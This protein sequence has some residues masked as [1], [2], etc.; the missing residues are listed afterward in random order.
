MTETQTDSPKTN[1]NKDGLFLRI[2]ENNKFIFIC[3]V[4]LA[5]VLWCLVTVY[6]STEIERTIS[7]IPVNIDITDSTP[8]RLGL[9]LFGDKEYYVDVTVKGP[10]YQL[11]ENMFT[12]SD[13]RVTANTGYIDTA[14]ETQLTLKAE[15]TDASSA[16][17]EITGLS[18]NTIKAYFD[19]V[20]EATFTLEPDVRFPDGID[21]V[22]EGYILD[23]PIVSVSTVTVSGPATEIA[24]IKRVVA[25]V[26]N[27][28]SIKSTTTSQAQIYM[29]T[30]NNI[31]PNYC[32]HSA[33]DV[34]VTMP[35]KKIVTV[36]LT[37][38]FTNAP[39]KYIDEKL[40][41][42]I[43]PKTATVALNADIA[44]STETISVGSIDFSDIN[45]DYNSFEFN[46]SDIEGVKFIDDDLKQ[47]TV[48]LNTSS[49]SSKSFNVAL[50][51]VTNVK[52]PNGY[53]VEYN[54]ADTVNVVAVGPEE[55]LETLESSGIFAEVDYSNT[56]IS[57]GKQKVKAVFYVKT[58]TDCWVYGKYDINAE[59][60]QI[61]AAQ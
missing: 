43:S 46:T 28:S 22:P 32:T 25:R 20:K 23:T 19:T 38:D 48:S 6:A 2:V 53:E 34:T 16:D 14:G 40:P 41:Y 12:A 33:T 27:S 49:M 29:I 55:S 37:V 45:N 57:V 30:D 39:I 21:S 17:V 59:I 1:R 44:D 5:F 11:S 4:L 8:E 13:I 7:N 35:V 24:K 3:S 54:T 61:A 15:I 50:N 56:E 18:R 36:P 26:E 47:I 9:Q 42:S 31:A 58:N 10:K 52:L 51:N 60:K